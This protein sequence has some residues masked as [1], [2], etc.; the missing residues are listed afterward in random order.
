MP[1]DTQTLKARKAKAITALRRYLA[2]DD[3]RL[4]SRHLEA[5]AEQLAAS[6]EHFITPDGR[7]DWGGRSYAYRRFMGDI[8][9]EAGVPAAERSRV[10]SALRWHVGKQLRATVPTEELAAL[11]MS[12]DT[13]EERAR[14]ARRR[15]AQAYQA[16]RGLSPEALDGSDVVSTLEAA[17][18]LIRAVSPSRV[19]LA[20]EDRE[21]ALDAV[22]AS[23][24]R[25]TRLARVLA[26]DEVTK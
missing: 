15:K 21:R 24:R 13:P 26:G 11:G 14:A 7:L 18:A 8:L 19:Q 4:R 1:H 16:L 12:E 17:L 22:E 25:L 2:E 5:V 20:E 23:R 6:R 3:E 9:S 10:S